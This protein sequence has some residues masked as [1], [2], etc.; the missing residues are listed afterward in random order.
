MRIIP[1]ITAIL[2]AA[3]LY[4]LIIERDKVLTFA[5]E[6]SPVQTEGAD[7]PD[8]PVAEVA[9]PAEAPAID[10]V[11]VFA[12]HSEAQEIDSAVVLR[13][14]TEAMRQVDVQAETSGSVISDPIRRGSFVE[15]GQV[16][17]QI[18]PGTRT[19]TLDEVLARLAEAEA[20]R[21]Q[22]EAR[23]PEAQA[24]LAGASAAL[25]EAQINANAAK[26][27]SADG[28]ASETRVKATQA[29][30]RSAEASVSSA[31]AGLKSAAA[32][33][34]SLEASI[35][36][37][38]AAVLRAETDIERLT[39]RA[40]FAGVL[41]SDTAELGSLLQSGMGSATCAT[42][43]QLDPIKLVGYVPETEIGRVTLGARA[44]AR[45]TDGTTVVG[46][47]TFVSRSADP[48]TRTF[49]VDITVDNSDLAI[50]DGQT[51][52]IAIAA[53]GAKA[54]L[55]PQSSLTLNDEGE[56][57]VRTLEANNTVKF[58]PVNLLRD[59]RQGVFVSG[60]PD[61]VNIITVGQEYVIDG[62]TVAPT[63]E[64]VTQ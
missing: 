49:R 23:I 57:G 4:G 8:T 44:G 45:M 17:C 20:Q 28:Y 53:A 41:E 18:D 54:H 46:D 9:P 7:A 39:I 63:Y 47:V 48:L 22:F 59:T 52:E 2:V 14:E 50:R 40:P 36:S 33:L 5:K 6:L 24:Q 51:A 3:L 61:R 35:Q 60:L 37:A 11:R 21:P 29:A 26:Q 64:E 56:L 19:A 62:V 32:G 58:I 30:V 13:G 31:E 43:I 25:E 27:L 38:R 1:V 12:V 34:D 15:A 42:I 16:L 10:G 55:L